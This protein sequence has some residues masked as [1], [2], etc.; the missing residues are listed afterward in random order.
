MLKE[1]RKMRFTD[2]KD[3]LDKTEEM[4]KDR[5]AY[6]LKIEEG[7]YEVITH[8]EFR[9]QI[10]QLGT[11][12]ID[13]GLKGERI[14]V[15]SENRYE[16]SLAYLAIAAGTGIV[17]P[18]DK[19]LPANEIE[20]LMIRSE[21]KAI[22]Y[23]KKYD[24]IMEDIRQR[25]TTQV[26]Y[27]ISM[28]EES[29]TEKVY[30]EKD[31]LKMGKELV[32]NGDTRFID[33]K[34]NPEEM[35]IMLFTSGTTSIS[36]AVMLSHKNIINNVMDIRSTF[37]LDETD[38]MLSFLPLHHVFECTVGFLYPISIGC[39]IAYCD[40]VKHMADNLKEYQITA[41]ISVPAVFDI[42][43]RKLLQGIDKK[44]KT[45][46]VKKGIKITQL[47]LKLGIDIRKKIFME[48][49]EN[50]GGK[51][52]LMV[53]GGA[54]LDPVTEKGFNELG[55]N[56]VQGYGLTETSPVIAAELTKQRRLGSIGKKFPSIEVRIEEPNE[57]GIG[58]LL[59]KG[60]TVMLGYYNNEE[61]TKEAIEEDGWFHTGDLARIDRDGY[62]YISGRKKNVIVLQNGKNI[63]PEEIEILINKIEGIKESII[64]GKPDNGDLSIAAKV[65]YDKEQ[66]KELYNIEEED[67]I[68]EF[69]WEEIKKINKT[70]PAYKYIRDLIITEEELIKTTTLK[71]KRHEEIKRII[72]NEK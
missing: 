52:R 4:Y 7:K 5:P 42:M 11:G 29:N 8:K 57:D 58:E 45:E 15:I 24:E 54:A 37:E 33:A 10:K 20:S 12:L 43:Y 21:V 41:I 32:I 72:S 2:L 51:I 6:K 31:I 44:G 66:M 70:M 67:K 53:A 62:I 13:L 38:R 71:V 23:S 30:S 47:L 22:F 34:I 28:D 50:L 61:A 25:G 48:I 27:F 64:Y 63:Y 1:M 59:A 46:T 19:S 55:F 56:L 60:P 65:V 9:Q 40:G 36:K 68:K 18:L 26:K 35:G 17:V 16:W 14:A 69:I 39:M 3:M 49:H